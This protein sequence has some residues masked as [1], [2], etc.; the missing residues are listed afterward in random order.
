MRHGVCHPA[1]PR[2]TQSK[3]CRPI[4]RR[5][6]NDEM[7]DPNRRIERPSLNN[8]RCSHAEHNRPARCRQPI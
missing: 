7:V 8:E 3:D 5:G 4:D 6:F 2:L 1:P